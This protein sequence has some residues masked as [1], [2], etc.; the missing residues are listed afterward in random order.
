MKRRRWVFGAVVVAGLL[1]FVAP[2]VGQGKAESASLGWS[3]SRGGAELTSY[4]FGTV[5]GGASVVKGFR[6]GNSSLTKSGKLAISVTGSSR[7]SITSD[8]CR[9]KSIGKKLWCWVGV[10]YRPVGAPASD[11]AT[12]RAT[13]AHGAIRSLSLCGSNAEPAGHL[14][15]IEPEYGRRGEPGWVDSVPRDGG[16]VTTL[17][18]KEDTP[19]ALAVDSTHVYWVDVGVVDEFGDGEPD[20]AVKEVPLGGGPVTTLA[21]LQ[22]APEAVAVDGTNVYWVNLN[23]TVNE[24]PVG[25]GLVTTLATGQAEPVSVA[26]DGTHV[27]WIDYGDDP[28]SESDGTVNEV[29][30]GGGPVTTLAAGQD[31]P[32]SVAVDGTHVYWVNLGKSLESTGTVN[33]VPAGGGP[34][35]TLA[36]GQDRPVS[37]AVDGTHVYWVNNG[38]DVQTGTVNKVPL[39]GGTVTTLASGQDFPEALALDST[40]VYWSTFDARL[41]K[42]RLDGGQVTR[43]A[44]GLGVSLAVG[45]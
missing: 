26:V 37:V 17:A 18:P 22:D 44:Y 15:F 19:V 45:P 24:V 6:L 39:G 40:H 38:I 21:T 3:R 42:V 10:A 33:E 13:G 12:L 27:Y 43:V 34:V 4:D 36:T 14:Y 32:V 41:N 9:M 29:P 30:V 31:R 20:G 5:D 28:L 2:A 11:S 8:K 35:I 1:A 16:C 7:F 23:G 25:G